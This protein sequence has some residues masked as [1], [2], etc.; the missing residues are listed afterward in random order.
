VTS[1]FPTASQKNYL[2]I[3]SCTEQ[4]AEQM[5]HITDRD[6][7]HQKIHCRSSSQDGTYCQHA[8]PFHSSD[9]HNKT[10]NSYADQSSSQKNYRSISIW[11]HKHN[12][13]AMC[14]GI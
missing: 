11:K 8:A 5:L 4:E 7:C 3:Y 2:K 13:S 14:W 10:N 9:I 1:K 12:G 6:K